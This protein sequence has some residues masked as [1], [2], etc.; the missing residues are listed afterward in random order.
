M[1]TAAPLL[2]GGTVLPPIIF[3]S[4]QKVLAVCGGQLHVWPSEMVSTELGDMPVF[5]VIV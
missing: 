2:R 1:V 5:D 4:F 3:S